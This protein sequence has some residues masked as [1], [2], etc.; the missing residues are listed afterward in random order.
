VLRTSSEPT[1]AT[2]PDLRPDAVAQVVT[3]DLVVRSLPEI[4]NSS[5]VDPARMP[6]GFLAYILDGPVAADGYDWYKVAPFP[7]T[8]SDVVEAHPEFGWLAAAGKDGEPWIAP[9]EGDCPQPNWDGIMLSQR[10]V[11]LSCW[12]GADVTLEGTLSCDTSS[13]PGG[14]PTWLWTVPCRLVGPDYGDLLAGGI[15]LHFPP[16]V[17]AIPPDRAPV[18]VTGHLDD[19]AAES[20]TLAP[21]PG[22]E[23]THADLVRLQCRVAFV[24]TEI[25]ER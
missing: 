25:T 3:T 5:A 15:G 11:A 16:D 8:L 22:T 2:E 19:P 14:E 6:I 23:P 17:G 10:R 18:R 24:V 20:C 13:Q 4:S 9:W 12:G 1:P 7:P 21:F